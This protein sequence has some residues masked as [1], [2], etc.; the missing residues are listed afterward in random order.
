[1]GARGVGESSRF[2]GKTMPLVAVFVKEKTTPG[3]VRYREEAGENPTTL[4]TV[5]IE[6]W[7]V[8]KY[9]LGDRIK[10]TVEPA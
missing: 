6:K 1:M 9:G 3:T 8:Q 4:R 5:Y 2:S 10:V 7:A